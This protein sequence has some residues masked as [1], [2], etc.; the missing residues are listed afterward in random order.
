[1]HKLYLASLFIVLVASG[2]C[3]AVA[4]PA[5][6]DTY[7]YRVV[8]AYSNETRGQVTYRVDNVDADRV[9]VLVSPDS[10]LG[11]PHREILTRDANWLRHTLI[12]HDMPVEYD[13][14]PAYP[15]YMWPLEPNKSWSIRVD[16]TDS[17]T[18]RRANVRVDG[19][20]LGSERITT[21]AG[22]FDTIKV[23][24]RVYA[25]D[26]DGMRHETNITETD[27]YAPALGRAARTENNSGYLYPERCGLGTCVPIR[28]DWNVFELVNLNK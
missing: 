19:E 14:S 25:G 9:T 28:G 22:T 6:G 2:T 13:F 21:P 17:A 11:M 1:M 15:A 24:R 20:V 8:N 16:A 3:V 5:I 27:W 18:G 10:S 23:R 12:N 4:A 7:V 26:W